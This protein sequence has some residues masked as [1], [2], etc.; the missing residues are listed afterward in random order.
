MVSCAVLPGVSVIGVLSRE[1]GHS[2]HVLNLPVAC[3]DNVICMQ[4]TKVYVG[5]LDTRI[6][7]RELED[8][9]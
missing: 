7:E 9:V 2:F 3:N 8:E 4:A 6:T 1:A 5:N